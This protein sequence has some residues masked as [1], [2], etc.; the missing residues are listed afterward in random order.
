M[1]R[2]N[3][4]EMW[5]MGQI[6]IAQAVPETYRYVAGYVTKKMYEIDEKKANSYYELGQTK[7]FA[8]MS[9]KPGIG[10]KWYEEHKKEIWEKGYIQ[11]TNG[12][13]AKIPRF[14]EKMME[15][16]NPQKLW[17]IKKERQAKIIESNR[18]TYEGIDYATELQ[19]KERIT[20]KKMHKSGKL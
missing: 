17:E 14:Y 4:G 15:Q 13:R 10:D 20:K 7:P 2:Q 16:E 12:K 8:K 18:Y 3:T 19:T 11:C 9:L 1:D 6:Q 5:K